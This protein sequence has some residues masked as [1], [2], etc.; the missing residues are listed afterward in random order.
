M[1]CQTRA[2]RRRRRIALLQEEL[3]QIG[4]STRGY[5]AIRS[6]LEH[7]I[8]KR[9]PLLNIAQRAEELCQIQTIITVHRVPTHGLNERIA[10]RLVLLLANIDKRHV[11]I[12]AVK[13]H[14]HLYQL[15]RI[16]LHT[17]IAQTLK[18]VR[19]AEV[20]NLIGGDTLLSD[21]LLG[22][23][24]VARKHLLSAI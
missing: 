18:R 7:G 21:V 13:R 17:A 24:N 15:T 14:V 16:A 1:H 23:L 11:R 22:K 5:A 9:R 2:S 8:G 4:V 19:K 3:T 10:S 6:A 20:L 12:Q